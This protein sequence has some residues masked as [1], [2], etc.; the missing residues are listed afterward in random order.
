M[1]SRILPVSRT[2]VR[3]TDKGSQRE[4]SA[5]NLALFLI[6][7]TSVLWVSSF[8]LNFPTTL[9]ILTVVGL[10]VAMIGL[11]FPVAGILGIG[12]LATL[13][14]LTRN[15]LLTG[16]LWRWNTL[17]YFLLLVMG[18]HLIF[19]LR[20][21]DLNTRLLQVFLVVLTLGL[22]ISPAKQDGIQAILNIVTLFGIMVYFA[23]AAKVKDSFFWLGIVTSVLSAVGS[24]AFYMQI[25]Q[26][27]YINPN[28]W[29]VFP[30]SGMFGAALALPYA[31]K[32]RYGR[33]PLLM[34]IALNLF[35]IFMSGSRG[36]LLVGFCVVI[37]AIL[38]LRSI[39]WTTFL[40]I[41]AALFWFVFSAQ[42]V[43][44]Q[45]YALSRL[46]RS[47]DEDRSLDS[48]TSGRSEIA[49][50]GLEVFQE[51]PLGVG[52]GGF[53]EEVMKTD[54]L[55]GQ[56][57]PA[58]SAWIRVLAENGIHG[59]IIFAAYIV[60]FSLVGWRKRK[61][62]MQFLFIGLLMT[63]AFATT[64]IAKEFA[65]KSLWFLAAG[66]TVFL[67]R[68]EILRNLEIEDPTHL[69]DKRNALMKAR[70]AKRP[71]S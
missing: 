37:Y 26:L 34:L 63:A 13:D 12:L 64:F 70:Y 66:V 50:A 2:I 5:K 18:L 54:I 3:D 51:N 62:D 33:L 8:V 22:I 43:E 31:V 46:E 48:R 65:G 30:L 25:E 19:L 68:E 15:F 52:T 16:G 38:M 6:L 27:E 61:I 41:S 44:Q 24:L 67:H 58:H 14:A 7:V 32:N 59:F 45:A 11:R 39:S 35:W 10:V 55:Y 47:F 40:M 56:A 28:A 23:R 17:N 69:A 21:N 4:P 9:S 60:S 42:F 20:L 53:V 49:L 1:S 57:R 36:S 71:R 29:S